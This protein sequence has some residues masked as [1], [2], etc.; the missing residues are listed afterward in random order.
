[1]DQT[2]IDEI[3]NELDK[4]NINLPSDAYLLG[5]H[6]MNILLVD[7]RKKLD[8]CE[9]FLR[10]IGKV[11]SIYKRNLV[12]KKAIKKIEFDNLLASDPEI[13]KEKNQSMRE[14]VAESKL[15]D[16]NYDIL[17]LEQ[18]LIDISALYDAV[19]SKL[20]NLN[21]TRVDFNRMLNLIDLQLK[22][23]PGSNLDTMEDSGFILEEVLPQ[24]KKI[25]GKGPKLD[26]EFDLFVEENYLTE[27][28]DD[29]SSPIK[30]SLIID[31][32]ES[33]IE[34][35]SNS[36]DNLNSPN[37]EE[38]ENIKN[39]SDSFDNLIFQDDEME[40]DIIISDNKKKSKRD[41]SFDDD[42]LSFDDLL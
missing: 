7:I 39:K 35:E 19:K 25:E 17:K 29:D 42:E 31:E 36:S 16:I 28:R 10:E 40:E 32:D 27:D 33:D 41:N 11:Q 38:K 8:K 26:E 6:K 5:P 14:S 21:S 4:F 1:M 13:R 30:H 18:H 12:N 37:V 34:D 24:E 15:K 3:Y 22:L 9:S 20:D 23:I 2:R